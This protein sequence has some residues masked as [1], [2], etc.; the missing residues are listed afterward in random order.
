[1]KSAYCRRLPPTIDPLGEPNVNPSLLRNIDGLDSSK[2]NQYLNSLGSAFNR[3]LLALNAKSNPILGTVIAVSVIGMAVAGTVCLCDAHASPEYGDKTHHLGSPLPHPDLSKTPALEYATKGKY[4]EATLH[5]MSST[6]GN[7]DSVWIDP[8]PNLK[9]IGEPGY[10]KPSKY[11]TNK[12][13]F[14]LSSPRQ[15]YAS[16]KKSLIDVGLKA[17]TNGP[18]NIT[19][20]YATIYI[21]GFENPDLIRGGCEDEL[22]LGQACDYSWQLPLPKSLPNETR[23]LIASYG[24][25]ADLLTKL[26]SKSYG[27]LELSKTSES[28]NVKDK[29][30]EVT[31]HVKLSN[32]GNGRMEITSIKTNVYGEEFNLGSGATGVYLPGNSNSFTITASKSEK[33]EWDGGKRNIH[34]SYTYE[35]SFGRKIAF[36]SD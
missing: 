18:T 24:F 7:S 22:Y 9:Q 20:D 2:L 31:Y 32:K 25:T 4:P 34:I 36:H 27:P 17:I 35:D 13:V 6:E 11:E 1:M 30:G 12:I 8:M 33:R 26:S 3:N 19:M 15:V 16:S 5:I 21:R 28:E 10:N 29:T 14:E 23:D